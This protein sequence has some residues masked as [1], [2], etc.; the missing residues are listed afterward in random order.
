MVKDIHMLV[1]RIYVKINYRISG[2]KQ[3]LQGLALLCTF[4]GVFPKILRKRLKPY[5]EILIG[6]YQGGFF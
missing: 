3:K 6:K 4:N 5:A 2:V 1:Q